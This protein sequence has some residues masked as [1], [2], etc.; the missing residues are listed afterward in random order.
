MGDD[1]KGGDVAGASSSKEDRPSHDYFVLIT[2]KKLDG[3]N[4]ASWSRSALLTITSCR[5][6][7]FINGKKLQRKTLMNMLNGQKTIV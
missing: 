2:L 5:M 4:Y 6:V 3:S 7:G 1:S